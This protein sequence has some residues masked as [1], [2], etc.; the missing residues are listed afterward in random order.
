MSSA[1][2]RWDLG[3]DSDPLRTFVA[4]SD[5]GSF[6]RAA[7]VV[8][9]TQSA[10]SLQMKR[11]EGLA[12][13]TLFERGSR[14]VAPTRLGMDLLIN[15]RRV[16]SLPEETSLAL[17]APPLIGPVRLGLP[18]EYGHAVLARALGTFAGRHPNVEVTVRYGRSSENLS[19]VGEGKLDLA[20]VFDWQDMTGG[21]ILRHDPTVWVTSSRH[22]VHERSPLPVAL[23]TSSGWC[24]DFALTFLEDRRITYRVAFTSDTNGGLKLAVTAGSAVAPISRSNVPEGCRELTSSEGFGAIDTSRLVLCR[25]ARSSSEA[26]E[27]MAVAIGEAFQAS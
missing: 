8:G 3:L 4:V 10:V 17:R 26:I 6:T 25:N 7:E 12:G 20:V 1:H 9:R 13:G 21:E 23:Y 5:T 27:G 2:Q 15:A 14:G 19:R 16:V 22:S 24:T 18:E 11:L